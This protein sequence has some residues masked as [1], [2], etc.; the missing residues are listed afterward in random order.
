MKHSKRAAGFT[1]VELAVALALAGLVSVILLYGVRVSALSLDRLSRH[2]EQVDDRRSVEALIRR[3]FGSVAAIPVYEGAASFVGAPS[4][5]KFLS[6]AEDGGPGLYRVEL[7][8]DPM[9]RD[10]P[11]I[12]S[13]RLANPTG[14]AR[15]Q[16]S[17]LVRDVT[18]FRIAYFGAIS[19]GDEPSWQPRWEG[20][21]YPPKLVRITLS[22]ADAQLRPPIVVRLW[23]AG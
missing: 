14:S 8:L 18:G 11:L 4:A 16:Q 9:R 5:V 19:P 10:R 2:A 6:L 15:F 3:A 7:A 12:L 17:V 13:R 22:G 1:L 21:A 20:L 23:N